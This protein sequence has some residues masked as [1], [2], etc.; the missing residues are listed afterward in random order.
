MVVRQHLAVR[1]D[2]D[3]GAGAAGALVGEARVDVDQTG[4]DRVGNGRARARARARIDPEP[5][6][7]REAAAGARAP[8]CCSPAGA[9]AVRDDDQSSWPATAPP[10]AAATTTT[11][12]RPSPART[13]RL[14]APRRLGPLPLLDGSLVSSLIACA[15]PLDRF[16]C[17][18]SSA[19][20]R[21]RRAAER[22]RNLRRQPSSNLNGRRDRPR[23]PVL[24]RTD[25]PS[26]RGSRIGSSSDQSGAR[27]YEP[28]S[29][30]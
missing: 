27:S 30:G 2:D 17:A 4:A 19:C 15:F 10:A 26:G 29:S 11:A 18:D 16:D 3:A 24:G 20:S 22:Q 1:A 25:R 13:S 23:H 21:T 9:L 8:E 7:A 14:G 28:D 12:R 5:R 6:R